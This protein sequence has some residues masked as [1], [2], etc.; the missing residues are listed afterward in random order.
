[1]KIIPLILLLIPQ[2]IFSQT[3]D[4]RSIQELKTSI[5]NS[6]SGYQNFTPDLT[7]NLDDSKKSTALGIIYSLLLLHALRLIA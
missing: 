3:S 1:M 6:E 7:A 5:K 4:L 2:V